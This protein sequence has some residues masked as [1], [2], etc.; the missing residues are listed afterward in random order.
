MPLVASCNHYALSKPVESSFLK[1]TIASFNPSNSSQEILL[2]FNCMC[3]NHRFWIHRA[4]GSTN[5]S[6]W[7]ISRKGAVDIAPL[8]PPPTLP[9]FSLPFRLLHLCLPPPAVPYLHSFFLKRARFRSPHLLLLRQILSR[10]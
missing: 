1:V 2:L 6:C 3:Q 5:D 9:F 4:H 7:A 8:T 10:H